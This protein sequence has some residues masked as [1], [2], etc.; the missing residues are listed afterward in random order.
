MRRIVLFFAALLMIVCKSLTGYAQETTSE[1]LG[2]ISDEK[3]A[4]LAGATVIAVHVPSGTKYSTTTRKDGRYNLPGLRVGG[5]YSLT[6]TYVGF[7]EDKQENITLTLGQAFKGDFKLAASGTALSEVIVTAGRQNKT[8]NNNHTGSVESINR[9]QIERMPT[10]NRSINDLV[11]LTP[12]ANG[13]SFGGASSAYNSVTLD[14][15]NFTNSF[16][17]GT[18]GGIL[19][20]QT[21]Q[22]PISLDAI[23][24][25]QI[26]ISPFDTRNGG[27]AGA[28][29]NA[30]TRSGTNQFKGSVYTY[31][32][33]P[34]TQGYRVENATLPR[35]AFS[36]NMRGASLGGAIVKNKLFFFIS[37]EQVRQTAP[38]TSYTA[39]SASRPAIKGVVSQANADTLKALKSFLKDKYQYDPGDYENYSYKSQSDKIAARIDWNINTHNTLTIKYNY[40]KSKADQ[41]PSGSG[42][43]VTGYTSVSR[44]PTDNALPF[45]GVGYGINNNFNIAIAELNTRFGN[46]ASNKFQ[47]GYTAIRDFR[48]SPSS[49][50]PLVDILSLNP[51]VGTASTSFGYEQFTYGNKLNTNVFQFSDIFSLY[52]GAHE[53]TIGTQNYFKNYLNGFAPQFAGIYQFATLQDFYNSANN[54]TGSKFFSRQYSAVPNVDFPFQKSG[55]IEL[56]FFVQDK[57]RV[58]NNFTLLYGVRLDGRAFKSTFLENTNFT[59]LTFNG[60]SYNTGQ[61]P[62]NNLA[63]SPRVGFNWD[64]MNDKSLQVRGGLG[65]FSGPPPFVWFSN[66]VGNNGALFGQEVSYTSGNLSGQKFNSEVNIT[67]P[68]VLQVP[69]TYVVNV[70]DPN[71]KYPSLFKA[72][73]GVDKKLPGDFILTLEG[74]Y[75]KDVN[76]T[77]FQNINLQTAGTPL[78]GADNRIRYTTPNNIYPGNNAVTAANPKL[79]SVI[80]MTNTNKGHAYTATA[81]LQKA[82]KNLFLSAAYTYSK[83]VN[84]NELGTTAA[85]LWGAKPVTGDPNSDA[86]GYSSYYQPHRVIAAASYRV[87]YAKHFATSIGIIFEAAP[88]GTTSYVYNGDVNNDGQSANDLIYVPKTQSDIVLVPVN[89]G[90]GVITDTRTANQIWAQ[91]NNYIGQDRY[92]AMHRGQYAGRNAVVY[93]FFKRADLN[94]TQDIY[95]YTGKKANADKHTLRLTLDCTN[96]GNFLNRNWGLYKF[97][98]LT[99]TNGATPLLKYEGIVPV[100]TADAGKPRYSFPYYDAGNQVPVASSFTN[101]TSIL[102]RWQMQFGIR[103]LFN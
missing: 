2:I 99:Q 83:S 35:Q 7:K 100:G 32:K 17:L 103:Y 74:T 41:P 1:I 68:S 81:Q 33:G 36:F 50:F 8:F 49:I 75:S 56:G 77:Y 61:K 102:S 25:L 92:L 86:T 94:I 13:L 38:S 80:L 9:T 91:L 54:G 64:V 47:V 55:S 90:S 16:G 28:G 76:A 72:T 12:S 63:V 3:G 18:V 24:Q 71:Y 78:A 31:L 23:E 52:A 10:I 51:S 42:P 82:F 96:I 87:E 14:G 37:G 11:K 4:P 40:F 34:G 21:N 98:T 58:A 60:K 65:I 70:T 43:S 45:S 44:S 95:F 20:S 88:A 84:T 62:K 101:N 27:F 89:T 67:P 73:L 29:I 59:A 46:K 97:T 6:T 5:P 69:T 15:A 26:N 30:V 39:S 48:T 53:L 79:S 22:T 19:G 93:P 66:Q 57:W 85:S